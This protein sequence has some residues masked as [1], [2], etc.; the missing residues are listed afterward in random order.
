MDDVLGNRV[1]RGSLC[2]EN[3]C[4]RTLGKFALLDLKVFINDV[5]RVHL[6]TLIFMQTLNLNVENGIRIDID[7]LCVLQVYSQF[8][9]LFVL[10]CQ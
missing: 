6:L 4:D 10:D 1:R 8:P 9:L 5:Q 2:T 3:D 7:I